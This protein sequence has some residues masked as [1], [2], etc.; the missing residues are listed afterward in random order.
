MHIDKF[1]IIGQIQD[2]GTIEG[3][4]SVNWMGHWIYVTKNEDKFPFCNAFEIKPGAYVRHPIPE[5]TNNGFGAYY[6]HA[7]DGVMSRDQLTGTIG[8]LIAKENYKAGERMLKHHAKRGF[9][10]AYNTRPNGED[11]KTAKW[12]LPD[13]TG[14]D[15]LA[16]MLRAAFPWNI[17]L[18]PLLCILDLH[19][20]IATIV[21]RYSGFDDDPISFAMKYM[22]TTNHCVTP[23]GALT[24][25]VLDRDKLLHEIKE[26]WSGWRQ[27]PEIVPYY[28]KVLK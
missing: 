12:Q 19:V 20:L 16:C 2:N 26:Y 4:D 14:P 1:G 8:A 9:L 28:E 11:P 21:H 27:T 18:Y 13:I 24:R 17:L 5:Q 10:F 23:A 25:K 15:M 6:N 3:G 7:W 22:I